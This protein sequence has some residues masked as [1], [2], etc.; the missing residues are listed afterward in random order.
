PWHYPHSDAAFIPWLSIIDVMM[1][2]PRNEVVRR[3][4]H[5]YELI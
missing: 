1:F 4:Q 5:G 3:L 2:N